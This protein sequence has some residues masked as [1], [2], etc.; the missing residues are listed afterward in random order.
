[1]GKKRAKSSDDNAGVGFAIL[2]LLWLIVKLFWWIVAAAVI[3]GV[4]F[5]AREAVRASRRRRERHARH[6]AEVCAR[7]D[8]QHSWVLEGDDR[9][10]FGVEGANLMREIRAVRPWPR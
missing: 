2:F 10:T 3:V 4:L 5:L 9:G 8:Q 1:M 7:A 6:C